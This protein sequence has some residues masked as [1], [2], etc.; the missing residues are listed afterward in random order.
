MMMS[1]SVL[2]WA[3]S[4]IVSIFIG[5]LNDHWWPFLF[6]RNCKGW[7]RRTPAEWL[8]ISE[9]WILNSTC[10]KSNV[11]LCYNFEIFQCGSHQYPEIEYWHTNTKN[12]AMCTNDVLY[13]DFSIFNSI[14]SSWE[15]FLKSIRLD[16]ATKYSGNVFLVSWEFWSL[17]LAVLCR[18]ELKSQ[19]FHSAFF[20]FKGRFTLVQYI[21]GNIEQYIDWYCW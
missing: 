20:V 19:F 10:F 5:G 8:V 18:V 15:M 13:F 4:S 7:R 17:I 6:L 16:E 2:L 21:V 12:F 14:V 1:C 11:R 3:G 9:K